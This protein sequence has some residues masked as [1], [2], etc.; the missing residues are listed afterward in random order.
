MNEI[1]GNYAVA[2]VFTDEI[3]E[4]ARAQ[5]Q[6]L[7]DNEAFE[8]CQIR[9]MPDVHPG[10]VG[11]IGFTS[12]VGDRVLPN[13]VGIDIGCGITTILLKQK[14]IEFQKLDKVI[15]EN[16]P[17]GFAVRRKAHRYWEEFDDSRLYC[18]SH[19][20]L[21]KASLSLGT[22]GGG[23]HFLEA[24][25]DM[26]GNLY[27]T[28][29]SGSRHL[30]KEVAEF[31]LKEGQKRLKD[32]GIEIPFEM[33]WLEG[34]LLEEYLHDIQVVQEFAALNRETILDELVKGMKWKVLDKI[35]SVHNYIEITDH[36]KI[37]RKGAV[38]AKKGEMVLIPVNMRD[39]MLLCKGKGNPDW[40][41]SA[42]HGAGRIMKREDV[43]NS[44]TVAQFKQE[45]KGIY[46]TCI[47]KD[48]LDEAPF[49]YRGI[50]QIQ[51]Q[52]SDTVDIVE[53]LLP[54]YN[55]KAGDGRKREK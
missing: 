39:G 28:V 16:V 54:I 37:L 46:C 33:T 29:H 20:D 50:A 6:L 32:M 5:I 3:E 21:E 19:V 51:D 47:G 13:V 18:R 22:L 38:S 35:Q 24:D 34:D 44:Y 8:G 30:G 7:C 52:L 17:S 14:K 43:K 49:A 53:R 23:N 55:F 27:M 42:P 1:R 11:T 48:T 12:T 41:Y 40:N 25:K 15:R 26:E 2:K 4:Y 10:K 45:M 31:Y 36:G 9:I